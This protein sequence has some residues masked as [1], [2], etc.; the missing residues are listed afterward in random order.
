MITLETVVAR[1]NEL[2]ANAGLPPLT[3]EPA[4]APTPDPV[5]SPDAE[6]AQRQENLKQP[7]Y[8]P[9]A[10]T[11][12]GLGVGATIRRKYVGGDQPMKVM[13]VG[14]GNVTVDIPDWLREQNPDFNGIFH[15]SDIV[16][17]TPAPQ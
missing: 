14:N 8:T 2:S 7:A 17:V 10:D 11:I 9:Q 16:L 12:P 5:G 4:P 6:E 13:Q 1:V 3:N 15:L